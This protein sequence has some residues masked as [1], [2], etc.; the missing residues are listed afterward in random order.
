MEAETLSARLVGRGV[1]SA[2]QTD[3]AKRRLLSEGFNKSDVL[4]QDFIDQLGDLDTLALSPFAETPENIV[5][6]VHR[7]VESRARAEKLASLCLGEVVFAF[8]ELDSSLPCCHCTG[9]MPS[10]TARGWERHG[11]DRRSSR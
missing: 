2:T 3:A 5:A 11:A 9:V 6:Q 1:E 4:T 8:H 10:P 7:K